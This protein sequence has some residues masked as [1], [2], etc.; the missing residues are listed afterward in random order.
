MEMNIE[1]GKDGFQKV[2][3]PEKIAEICAKYV[4]YITETTIPI[5]KEFSLFEKIP[6]ATLY[7]IPEFRELTHICTQKKEVALE[8]K[9]QVDPTTATFTIFSLKQLGWKDQH[10]HD[11]GDSVINVVIKDTK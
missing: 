11:L 5:V 8:R 1:K 6:Y 3:T 9:G 2:Y 4:K 7:E 10:Q